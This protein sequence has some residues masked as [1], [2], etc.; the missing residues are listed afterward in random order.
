MLVKF[1]SG[2]V[3][4]AI[5]ALVVFSLMGGGLSPCIAYLISRHI[6]PRSF[7]SIYQT[8]NM[9]SSLTIGLGPLAANYIFDQV[10]SYRPVMFAAIPLVLIGAL[11]LAST[12]RYPEF[13]EAG[14]D[15]A[16]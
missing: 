12:G 8:V 10:H 13:G 1:R 7:A 9:G 16:R 6:G 4:G 3:P 15:A 14:R 5:A 2:S 11:L